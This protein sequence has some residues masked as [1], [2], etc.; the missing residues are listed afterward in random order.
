M[1]DRIIIGTRECD[2]CSQKA[3][4]CLDAG[5]GSSF[6]VAVCRDCI[7]KALEEMDKL[8]TTV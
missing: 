8:E 6:T 4:I 2:V 3:P 7:T 1:S 5:D